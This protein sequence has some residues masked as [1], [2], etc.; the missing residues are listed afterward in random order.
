V[1]APH[2]DDEA[3]ATGGL[4]PHA[5][6]HGAQ[7]RV[8]FLTDGENNPWPQ[9]VADRRWHIGPW[10]RARWGAR[11]RS[12]ALRS[13]RTLG[14]AP[15]CA[16][17]LGL[18]DQRLTSLLAAGDATLPRALREQFDEA[19]PTHV[20]GPSTH[21]HHPDHSALSIAIRAE[22]AARSATPP[23]LFEYV[24]HDRCQQPAGRSVPL[25]LD[26]E[27]VDRKRRAIACHTSQL[28][29]RGGELL[30]FACEHETFH[31]PAPAGSDEPAHPIR[32][33]WLERSRLAIEFRRAPCMRAFGPAEVH[34]VFAGQR[35]M[36]RTF[37]VPLPLRSRLTPILFA[38]GRPYGRLA[39]YR[40]GPYHGV[41]RLPLAPLPLRLPG[42]VKLESRFGF[43][44]EA[45][46]RS[47]PIAR[48]SALLP[49]RAP[50]AT[51]SER[52]P[53]S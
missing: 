29:F 10:E 26:A 49:A 37:R 21:D 7:V 3:L 47:L 38:D 36:R 50:A 14:L 24:V 12:E 43:F 6:A 25:V 11:R 40:G 16:T 8:A 20:V 34:L 41:L 35:G 13:L 18:P 51:V 44:D 28:F 4:I 23:R 22:C 52:H 5:L 19:Q 17:F 9:R 45:G 27:A 15:E 39:E 53:G 2:P 48:R 32:R 1:F 31:V 42:Y 30:A 46:W 33:V